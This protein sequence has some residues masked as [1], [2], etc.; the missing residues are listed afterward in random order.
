MTARRAII[1]FVLVAVVAGIGYCIRLANDLQEL[2]E[3]IRNSYAVWWVADMVI[4]HQLANEGAWPRNW[5]DLRDD[6]QTCVK[7]SGQPWTFEELRSRVIVDWNADPSALAKS[8]KTTDHPEFRVIWLRDGTNAHW[9]S[10]E[11]NHIIY[12]YL[13][14][15]NEPAKAAK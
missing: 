5:D 1:C 2:N 3:I 12:D 11:P 8:A 9:E 6:Y 13:R 14:Q 15:E 4:E 10:H 7:R